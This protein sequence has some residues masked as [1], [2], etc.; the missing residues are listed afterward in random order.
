[1]N[2][3]KIP[4]NLETV[5]LNEQTNYKLIEIGKNKDYFDQEVKEQQILIKKLCKYI[6][7]FDYTYKILT[8]F[9]P[10]FSGRNIFAHAKDKKRLSG[11]ITSVF[12]LEKSARITK[13]L[14]YETKKGKR[15]NK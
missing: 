1:M 2:K 10:V 15:H 7:G 12:S 4:T 3:L 14:L 6:T 9:L 13:Q 11:L 8:V 5:S